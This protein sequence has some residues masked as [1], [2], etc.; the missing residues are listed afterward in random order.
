MMCQLELGPHGRRVGFIVKWALFKFRHGLITASEALQPLQENSERRERLLP[1]SGVSMRVCQQGHTVNGP[2]T[3]G[4]GSGGDSGT[5]A[6]QATR[7]I[8]Q[9]ELVWTAPPGSQPGF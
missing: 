1:T 4:T 3:A 8:A 2:S 5:A 6:E 7:W 9:S